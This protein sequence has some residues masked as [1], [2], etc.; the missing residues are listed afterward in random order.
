MATPQKE[1]GHTGIANDILEH[2]ISS[3]LNGTEVA[4][5]LF[6]IRKTY[7]YQKKEDEISLSQ[8]MKA[9]PASKQS[10]VNATKNLQL[11][12]ILILVKKGTSK[13][14]SNIWSFNKD[15][16]TWQLV[17]KARLVKK[18]TIQLVKKTRHTKEIIQK[19]EYICH[20]ADALRL[21]NLFFERIRGHYQEAKIPDFNK[22]GKEIEKIINIDKRD[23]EHIE[24]MINWC[25]SDSFWASNIMSPHK[26]RQQWDKLAVRMI[27]NQK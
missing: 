16:D 7:G 27:T 26:L 12:K 14:H 9:V 11:V 4:C 22:W 3:G 10:I 25:Q 23:P 24:Y 8:F 2:I 18:T 20:N 5:V 17:K 21:A 15:Y 6:V 13:K 1:N 19:K